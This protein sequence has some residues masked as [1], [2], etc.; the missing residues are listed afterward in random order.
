MKTGI[1]DT[2]HFET[3]YALIRLFDV[4]ENELTIFTN[5]HVSGI[6]NQ[7]LGEKVKRYNWVVQRKRESNIRFIFRIHKMLKDLQPGLFIYSTVRDNHLLHAWLLKKHPKMK[8]VLTLH[9]INNVTGFFPRFGLRPIVR[10]I[11]ARLL[12]RQADELNVLAATLKKHLEKKLR[13][14]K[15]GAYFAR[16]GL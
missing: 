16:C 7:M 11:G 10:N 14:K 8:S 2:E 5:E 6:L 9:T 12:L 4:D 3:A 15:N 1:F 13:R